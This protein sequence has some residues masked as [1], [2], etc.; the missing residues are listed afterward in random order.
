MSAYSTSSPST[1]Q[2]RWYLIRPPSLAWTW[3]N[4]MSLLSVAEYS[5]TGTLTRP[6]ETAPFQIA[7]M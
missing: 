6:N 4:E 1:L 2:T 3:R 5:F 7:R